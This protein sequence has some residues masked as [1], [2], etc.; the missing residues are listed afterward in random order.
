[1][2]QDAQKR[3]LQKNPYLISAQREY[4]TAQQD[5]KISSI[6]NRAG[7]DAFIPGTDEDLRVFSYGLKAEF[8]NFLGEY[9]DRNDNIDIDNISESLS[10]SLSCTLTTYGGQDIPADCEKK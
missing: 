7:L 10:H 4:W 1:M 6:L 9:L 3:F 8:E 2:T 5:T